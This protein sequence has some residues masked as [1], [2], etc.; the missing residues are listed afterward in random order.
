MFPYRI[1]AEREIEV[2]PNETWKKIK[3]TVVGGV[4]LLTFLVVATVGVHYLGYWVGDCLLGFGMNQVKSSGDRVILP[5]L[6]GLLV[7]CTPFAIYHF[8]RICRKL[9]EEYIK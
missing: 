6:F 3:Q 9:G 5:W 8:G 2:E 7:V 4:I 1:P